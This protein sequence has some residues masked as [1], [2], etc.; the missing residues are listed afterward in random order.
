MSRELVNV[1]LFE[2]CETN[3]KIECSFCLYG[4]EGLYCTRG[5]CLIFQKPGENFLNRLPLDALSIPNYVIKKGAAHGARHGKTAVQ[6]E[7]HLAWNAWK[8]RLPR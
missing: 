7:Y 1:E 8:S 3:P 4:L 6:R 5:H 2:L